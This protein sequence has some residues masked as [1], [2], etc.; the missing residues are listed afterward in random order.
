[1]FDDTRLAQEVEMEREGKKERKS[2]KVA[3]NRSNSRNQWVVYFFFPSSSAFTSRGKDGD[4][5]LSLSLSRAC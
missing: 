4:I 1:M 2:P 3:V 5:S